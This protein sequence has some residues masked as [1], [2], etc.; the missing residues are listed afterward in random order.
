MLTGHPHPGGYKYKGAPKAG[1]EEIVADGEQIWWDAS[2]MLDPE[3]Q[4]S[5]GI[6]NARSNDDNAVKL[7]VH[8]P[9]PHT[10]T[11]GSSRDVKSVVFLKNDYSYYTKQYKMFSKRVVTFPTWV[12]S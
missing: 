3:N 6:S 11:K 8:I 12:L 2:T 10:H 5:C 7:E 1:K 4:W 9:P